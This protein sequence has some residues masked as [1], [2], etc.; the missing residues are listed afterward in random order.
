MS[1]FE[2]YKKNSETY[3]YPHKHCQRCGEMIKESYT[4]CPDCYKLLK[5][6][7][8]K[9]GLLNRIKGIFSRKKEQN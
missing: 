2:R 1:K 5:E 4:Y 7:K 6:K 3:I 9:K 8:K